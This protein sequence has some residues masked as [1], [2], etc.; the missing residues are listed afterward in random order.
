MPRHHHAATPDSG[1]TRCVTP[2]PVDA[3]RPCVATPTVGQAYERIRCDDSTLN[4]LPQLAWSQDR[5]VSDVVRGAL[6]SYPSSNGEWHAQ[7]QNGAFVPAC[8]RA[9][10]CPVAGHCGGSVR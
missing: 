7:R 5:A 2:P 4:A 8:I 3:P 9:S 6:S 10:A 1:R